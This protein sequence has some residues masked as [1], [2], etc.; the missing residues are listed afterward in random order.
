[1]GATDRLTQTQAADVASALILAGYVPR[2]T[3][4]GS[5]WLIRVSSPDGQPIPAQTV[6]NFAAA[7]GVIGQTY[8]AE[9]A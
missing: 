9:L 4:S 1:M 8:E 7:H 3:G 6:A 5:S 2:I